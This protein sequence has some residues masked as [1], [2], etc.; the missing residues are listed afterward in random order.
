MPVFVLPRR[1]LVLAFILF[2]LIEF[3]LIFDIGGFLGLPI[4]MIIGNGGIDFLVGDDVFSLLEYDPKGVLS[5]GRESERFQLV[6]SLSRSPVIHH[7]G[8]KIE[9]LPWTIKQV[10]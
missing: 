5:S 3:S 8:L 6:I 2:S 10:K 9:N 4:C 1:E 7:D